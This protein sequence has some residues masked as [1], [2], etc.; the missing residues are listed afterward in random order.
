M[1]YRSY[2]WCKKSALHRITIFRCI[3]T[4]LLIAIGYLPA[5]NITL[6]AAILFLLGSAYAIFHVL[7]LS[8]SMEIMPEGKAGLYNTII[9]FGEA[10]GSFTGSFLAEAFGFTYT[11]LAASLSFFAA[12]I[13]F[14]ITT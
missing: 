8:I 7:S 12:Y 6:A 2:S 3:L 5:H 9:G 4:S 13:I 10:L 1:N 11:F 14:K